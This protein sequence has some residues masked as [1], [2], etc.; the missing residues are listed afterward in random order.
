[1]E[2]GGLPV[3]QLRVDEC[4]QI[5][6]GIKLAQ[7]A[8]VNGAALFQCAPGEWGGTVASSCLRENR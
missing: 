7:Q 4:A 3:W 8:Q 6:T 1:M 5:R 2:C